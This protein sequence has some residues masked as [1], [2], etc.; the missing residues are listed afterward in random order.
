MP[1]PRSRALR[2]VLGSALLI[3]GVLG[4]LPVIGFWMMPLGLLV[5]SVDVSAIRRWRR[6]VEVRFGRWRQRRSAAGIAAGL[7]AMPSE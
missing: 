2:I 4:F 5:L 1:L 7:G 3:C 6:R